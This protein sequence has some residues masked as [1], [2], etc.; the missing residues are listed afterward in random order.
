MQASGNESSSLK[1]LVDPTTKLKT[2]V[3]VIH[4]ME[5]D[6]THK[7]ISIKNLEME[8][9]ALLPL[10][11]GPVRK[12]LLIFDLMKV[13]W[14]RKIFLKTVLLILNLFKDFHVET[15]RIPFQSEVVPLSQGFVRS[16]AEPVPKLLG[17]ERALFFDLVAISPKIG[18]LFLEMGFLLEVG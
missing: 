5:G 2:S 1:R 3:F 13:L 6:T 7:K 17:P 10:L 15:R 8:S 12:S 9:Q 16:I 11:L 14:P 18:S 4:R